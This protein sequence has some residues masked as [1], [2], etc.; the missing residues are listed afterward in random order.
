MSTD[1][2]TTS[3][4]QGCAPSDAASV[5]AAPTIESCDLS[6]AL[7]MLEAE[8]MRTVNATK[9]K[10]Q[11]QE[12]IEAREAAEADGYAQIG[13]GDLSGSEDDDEGEEADGEGNGYAVLHDAEEE[14]TPVPVQSPAA[15][16]SSSTT[17]APWTASFPDF[18]I[19]PPDAV[20]LAVQRAAVSAARQMES[21]S[22][23]GSSS[24][25][26]APGDS[27][28]PATDSGAKVAAEATSGARVAPSGAA[29]EFDVVFPDDA[30]PADAADAPTSSAAAPLPPQRD[31]PLPPDRV[32]AIKATMAG[33]SLSLPPPDWA[34][35]VPESVWMTTLLTRPPQKE[36]SGSQTAS[37]KAGKKV[38]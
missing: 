23:S 31:A 9:D 12:I 7:S 30:R 10:L 13:I 19:L 26:A 38:G 33:L 5:H 28:V 17:A 18:E 34:S 1:R 2:T 27:R 3:E 37:M 22:S 24:R 6:P 35:T 14:E 32:N 15:A 25:G 29:F 8:Y 21:G 4:E 36:G 20:P 11:P 16:S